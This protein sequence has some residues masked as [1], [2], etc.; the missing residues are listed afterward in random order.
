[1]ISKGFFNCYF[2]SFLFNDRTHLPTK[3]F[4]NI[5]KAKSDL[6]Y[7]ETEKIVFDCIQTGEIP[8]WIKNYCLYVAS[9]GEK[10]S[11]QITEA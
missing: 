9:S 2:F 7:V 10:S 8:N 6:E 3:L 4:R 11:C 5:G 1:M